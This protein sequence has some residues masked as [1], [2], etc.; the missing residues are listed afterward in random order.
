MRCLNFTDGTYLGLWY[1]WAFEI[2]DDTK[3]APS[4]PTVAISWRGRLISAKYCGKSLVTMWTTFRGFSGS[5]GMGLLLRW[6]WWKGDAWW[7]SRDPGRESGFN[8]GIGEE[9]VVGVVEDAEVS[10]LSSIN[11][12]KYFLKYIQKRI[13]Y[14]SVS[15]WPFWELLF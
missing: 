1:T 7:L 12:W 3:M 4:G 15:I 10:E 14:V 2:L 6:D 5:S 9:L 8:P 13:A 11:S